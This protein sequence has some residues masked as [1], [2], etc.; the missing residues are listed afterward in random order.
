MPKKIQKPHINAVSKEKTIHPSK[1]RTLL[2]SMTL[3][4]KSFGCAGSNVLATVKMWVIF[5]LFNS[6]LFEAAPTE[7]R[8]R[9]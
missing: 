8:K 9:P 2:P 4:V 1:E 6:L 5:K 3:Y 7:P